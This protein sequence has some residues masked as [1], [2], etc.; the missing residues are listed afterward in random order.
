M[1]LGKEGWYKVLPYGPLTQAEKDAL[2]AMLPTLRDEIRMG[3]EFVL[4]PE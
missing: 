3:E 4:K 2:E 1:R